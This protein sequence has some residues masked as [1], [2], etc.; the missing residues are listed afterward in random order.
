MFLR[1]REVRE[2]ITAFQRKYRQAVKVGKEFGVDD[3][4]PGAHYG[5]IIDGLIK[6]E[7]LEVGDLIEFLKAPYDLTKTL[8]GSNSVS[9]FGSL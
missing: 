3:G 5:P 4:S 1:C 9:G 8:E 6:D 7:W 2:P